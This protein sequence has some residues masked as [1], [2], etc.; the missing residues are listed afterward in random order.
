[1]MKK[2]VLG[3]LICVMMS[4]IYGCSCSKEEATIEYGEKEAVA[5][6]TV[7][8]SGDNP[9]ISISNI[10]AK[11]GADIDYLSNVVIEDEDKFDDLEIWVDESAVD[12]YEAGD[13]KAKYTF[14]YDGKSIEY[15]I[16]VTILD[17]EEEKSQTKDKTSSD[18]VEEQTTT[19]NHS[20]NANND[21]NGNESTTEKNSSSDVVV[22]NTST[23]E[24]NT[25]KN[26]ATSGTTKNDSV[27]SSTT[28]KDSA[29]TATTKKDSATTTTSKNS[30]TS[31]T[32][33]NDSTTATTRKEII[34]TSGNT[35]EAQNIGFAYIEL[36]S[37][38][39]VSIKT[40]TA[41]YIVST[42]TDVSYTTRNGVKYKVSKLIITY[43]TGDERTLETVEEKCN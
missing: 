36:L 14:K 40:T 19:K 32:T 1:M 7:D 6:G 41:K 42:R 18:Y 16:T 31:S 29:T 15:S 12:I 8:L 21:N 23:T 10:K 26:N 9:K 25:S 27:E 37:G 11:K 28:K 35:T 20:G 13:Y 43:N 17:E 30:A 3:I 34:T 24:K 5:E 22:Q 38:K 4:V 2:I 33:K 39:T